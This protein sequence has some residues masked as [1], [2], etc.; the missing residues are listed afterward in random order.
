M[1]PIRSAPSDYAGDARPRSICNYDP[2]TGAA[3]LLL[4]AGVN[5]KAVSERLGHVSTAFTMDTY[6]HSLPTVQE[7]AAAA[8][9]R[10]IIRG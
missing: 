8:L 7:E 5:V 2:G 10:I 9:E 3:S 4:A 6:V 1:V